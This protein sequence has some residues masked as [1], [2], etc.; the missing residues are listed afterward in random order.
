MPLSCRVLPGFGP[1]LGIVSC[2]PP[3]QDSARRIV[4]FTTRDWNGGNSSPASSLVLSWSVRPQQ[5]TWIPSAVCHDVGRRPRCG[6]VAISIAILSL[7]CFLSSPPSTHPSH[8]LLPRSI[9]GQRRLALR[10]L[11]L[12]SKPSPAHTTKRRRA[13]PM[14]V[15]LAQGQGMSRPSRSCSRT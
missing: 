5:A 11:G 8:F 9:E 7:T 10:R 2:D 6:D 15:E 14:I 3:R 1:H 12:G 13:V 4:Q